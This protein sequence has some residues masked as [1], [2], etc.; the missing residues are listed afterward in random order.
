MPEN[1]YWHT[2]KI[3]EIESILKTD[4]KAG[5]HPE[6][7][8]NRLIRFGLNELEEEKKP[9][10][11]QIFLSQ[12]K[13]FLVYVL[14]VAIIISGLLLKELVDALAISAILIL[15][16]ILGFVQEFRAEKAMEALKRLTAPTAKVIRLGQEMEIPAKELV[17]GDLI[18]LQTGDHV[19]A[20]ARIMECT[21]F[22]T[23]ESALT[24]ESQPVNKHTK[25][26][27]NPLLP[28]GDR[29]NMVYMGTAAARGR[30]KAVVV[31]TGK[32]TEMGQIAG[33]LQVAGEKTPLQKELKRVGKRIALLCLLVCSVVFLSGILRGFSWALMF[34]AAVS[35]AVA[36]IPEGLPAVVTVTLAL[37]VQNMA[38]KNAIVRRLHAVETL[39]SATAICTDK[40]G[41]LTKNQMTVNLI[42]LE[43]KMW[44]LTDE[45]RLRINGKEI[46]PSENIILLFKIAA[47]CN[48]ARFRDGKPVG[49]PTEGALLIA[50]E[51][52]GLKKDALEKQAPR[53]N[54]I[55][56]DS[57]R[58]RMTTVHKLVGGPACRQVGQE[59]RVEGYVALVK[60]APEVVLTRCSNIYRGGI[61][62]LSEEERKG[63]LHKNGS[64]ARRGYRV[65]AMAYREFSEPPEIEPEALE[66][67][68][69]FVGLVGMTDPPRSEV[70]GAIKTCHKA[71]VQV[72]MV[73]GDHKLT[74]ETI[75]KEIDLL[76]RKQVITGPELKEISEE[77]LT[78]RIEE[79]AVYARVDPKDKI[80]IIK[81]FKNR[82]HI[83]GMTGDGVN[84]APA[85]KMA[86]IGIAMG[87]AGTDVTKE[88]SD[89][90][91]TDDNFATI[92]TAIREGRSIFDNIKKF[93]LFLLSCN[94]SEVLTMFLAMIAGLP[95]PLLP[96]QILWINLVTDGLPA[97]ALGTDPPAPDLMHRPPRQIGEGILTKERQL[98][99]LWQGLVLALGALFAF[100]AGL[101]W[102][103]IPLR[104][105]QSMVFTAMV[106]AQ[107]L[108][109]LNFRC[110]RHS[111][112]TLHSLANKPLLAAIWGSII[113]H[114]GVLY[115]PPLQSIF[116]TAFLGTREWGIILTASLVPL[117]I[118]DALRNAIRK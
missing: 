113:L 108:H 105:A 12:F 114:L 51:K 38:K 27:S 40:T 42:Y 26:V 68:L 112:F 29:K 17:P 6:Q 74:A 64:M 24:G 61:K 75:A 97:L 28:L 69:T 103:K 43:D 98:Q 41:T 102:L 101:F 48:D 104:S 118:V 18:L 72:A 76:D 71:K 35:L 22:A 115:I 33:M 3:R 54:E 92:V 34:L 67:D 99:I 16:A 11:L 60:G 100:M 55:P 31:A 93:I 110:E 45:G 53:L 116:H 66:K 47:L 30:A 73:T 21:A 107:I 23:D 117:I 78:S 15:N 82:G 80:K 81:A 13:D 57:E 32:S 86:D 85:V 106:L 8:Q 95:L 63:L 84:D 25:P 14:I 77:E 36:A 83:V 37:G 52:V 109:T 58:K 1:K 62:P 65:L 111:V 20:D 96:I 46:A 87:I 94:V 39:G 88:A 79:I 10:P 91:L 2:L 9:T 7:A 70:Y 5:L 59:S 44:K 4:V 56:F 50:A 49:D 90:T 89:I 19:P